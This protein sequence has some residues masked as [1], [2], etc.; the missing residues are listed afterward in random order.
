MLIQEIQLIQNLQQIILPPVQ[1]LGLLIKPHPPPPL[2][3][4]D[5]IEGDGTEELEELDAFH[6]TGIGGDAVHD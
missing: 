5:Y 2:D 4:F 1:E 6:C 3:S